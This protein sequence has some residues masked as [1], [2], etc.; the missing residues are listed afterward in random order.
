V[1][2]SHRDVTPGSRIYWWRDHEVTLIQEGD[3]LSIHARPSNAQ[4][5]HAIRLMVNA[6]NSELQI[7]RMLAE[8]DAFR[9]MSWPRSPLTSQMELAHH[10]FNEHS[11]KR[12]NI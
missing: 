10:N 8:P 3:K 12:R 9:S 1:I 5:E 6:I 2:F 7:C 4:I 11:P